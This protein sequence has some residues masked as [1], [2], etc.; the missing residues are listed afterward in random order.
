[1]TLLSMT[2]HASCEDHFASNPQLE[3]D[4]LKQSA[5]KQQAQNLQPLLLHSMET[6]L[7]WLVTRHSALYLKCKPAL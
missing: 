1:M 6:D 2:F 3:T 7:P 4:S 5:L